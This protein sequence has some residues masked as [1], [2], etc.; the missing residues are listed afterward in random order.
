MPACFVAQ[1]WMGR[2]KDGGGKAGRW[3][4]RPTMRI[5]DNT[6]THQHFSDDQKLDTSAPAACVWVLGVCAGQSGGRLRGDE[7]NSL[8]KPSA[9]HCPHMVEQRMTERGDVHNSRAFSKWFL[10]KAKSLFLPFFSNWPLLSDFLPP[11]L[12]IVFRVPYVLHHRGLT[13]TKLP[14]FYLKYI[15]M[16]TNAIWIT[17]SGAG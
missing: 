3:G 2:C 10:L 8:W 13:S 17:C 12:L 14:Y 11:W 9:Q 6:H 7:M 15:T 1:R 4:R 16:V 5:C